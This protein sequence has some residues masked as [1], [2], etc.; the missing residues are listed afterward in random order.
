MPTHNKHHYCTIIAALAISATGLFACHP[1]P[2]VLPP[3]PPPVPTTIHTTGMG[4]LRTW[5]GRFE[6]RYS[7]T[8]PHWDT[9]SIH[10]DS[11]FAL[12]I[13]SPDSV[14]AFNTTYGFDTTDTVQGIRYFG[15]ARNFYIAHTGDGV[16]YF[17]NRDS[18]AIIRHSI[19]WSHF[20]EREVWTTKPF[21]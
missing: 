21:R 3:L 15:K 17:Y 12:T 20:E 9:V 13:I 19:F 8:S 10:P 18:I 1:Q 16:A 14:S 2:E 7:I 6:R 4:S 11:T 5:T